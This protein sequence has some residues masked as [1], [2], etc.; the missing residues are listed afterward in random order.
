MSDR[1]R[2]VGQLARLARLAPLLLLV[3]FVG[4]DLFGGPR[5]IVLGLVVTSPLLAASLVGPRLT[6]LYGVAA[7]AAAVL[8]GFSNHLYG[9]DYAGGLNAQLVRVAGVVVG[10]VAAVW[11]SAGRQA[12]ERRLAA[13]TRI[14][15][16]AQRTILS[17]LPSQLGG[18]H[19]AVVYES[20]AT[21]ALVGGDLYEAVDTLWGVRLLIGDVRGKGLDAVRLA[22]RVLG[23]FRSLAHRLDDP[24]ALMRALDAEVAASAAGTEDFVT[25]VL[26]QIDPKGRTV[27]L[28]AGHPD[29]LLLTGLDVVEVGPPDRQPPLGLGTF[30]RPHRLQLAP[31]DRLLLYTDGLAEARRKV[32]R[33]FFPVAAAVRETMANHALTAGLAE[34]VLRLRHWTNG[35]LADDVALL[36]VE[37]LPAAEPAPAVTTAADESPRVTT[38][39]RP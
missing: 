26:V 10:S 1:S 17:P 11:A 19:L 9:G 21:D 35:G 7:T 27:V 23:C 20:A 36:A 22:S 13:V 15:E 18:L 33:D 8:L 29:P 24:A 6:A 2:R 4:A 39:L 25:A 31:A 34:L 3:A 28:N 5:F 32:T 30:P 38:P 37:R 16:V 12:R 14:A